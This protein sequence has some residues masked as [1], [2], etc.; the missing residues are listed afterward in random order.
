MAASKTAKKKLLVILGAG[1]SLGCG[2]PSVSSLESL[3]DRWA[4]DWASN[5]RFSN[6]Y[7][8][9]KELVTRYY[10]EGPIR[11]RPSLNFEMLLGQMTAFSHWMTPS[12][13]GDP[14]REVAC[15]G[16]APQDFVFVSETLS[17]GPSPFAAT[18]ELTSQLT[19]LLVELAR[20]FRLLCRDVDTYSP[21]SLDYKILADQLADAFDVGVFNL[22]YDTLAKL[23]WPEFFNGFDA[24]GKF[25]ASQI[26]APRKRWEFVYHLHGSVHHSLE[27]RWGNGPIAWRPDLTAPNFN[28]GDPDLPY[29]K[30]SEGKPFP[31]TTLVAGGFKLDQMLVEPFHSFHAALIRHVYEADAILIGGYGFGDEH[32]NR[33]LRNPRQ[34]RRYTNPPP[35]M[36]LGHAKDSTDPMVDRKDF[37]ARGLARALLRADGS[38]FREVGEP[39][40]RPHPLTLAKK[41]AFEVSDED[42]VALWHAGFAEAA[43]R[44]DD[45]VHWL[46]GAA[47]SVLIAH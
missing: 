1:S 34:A 14:L 9:V 18:T 25:S 24:K 10:S 28:D 40:Q 12:P 17:E 13:L 39:E 4:A 20:H 32:V 38:F 46:S 37:W 47:D 16:E 42:R 30:R 6:H 21:A 45:I 41:R 3:F 5:H 29:D 23:A 11:L 2:M 22:N 31:V 33:A 43:S 15:R 8:N 35:V 19:H 36:V 7:L 26:H 44:L 27:P